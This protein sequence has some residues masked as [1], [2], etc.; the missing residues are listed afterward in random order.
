M[1]TGT[2]VGAPISFVLGS[3][4]AGNREMLTFTNGQEYNTDLGTAQAYSADP[5]EFPYPTA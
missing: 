4:A 5:T 1:A 3:E 2:V